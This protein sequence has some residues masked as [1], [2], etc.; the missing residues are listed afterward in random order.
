[1][2]DS[3]IFFLYHIVFFRIALYYI[4]YRGYTAV[5]SVF[6]DSGCVVSTNRRIK[7][8]LYLRYQKKKDNEL[9]VDEVAFSLTYD[10][11]NKRF[12]LNLNKEFIVFK[13]SVSKNFFSSGDNR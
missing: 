6:G 13:G 10:E 4:N 5:N 8:V 2:Q 7:T 3:S 11:I 9:L 1:M 12:V